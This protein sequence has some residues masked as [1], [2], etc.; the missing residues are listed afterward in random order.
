MTMVGSEELLMSGS[1]SNLLF[2]VFSEM[3]LVFVEVAAVGNLSSVV[4]CLLENQLENGS[5]E[6]RMR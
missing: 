4:L 1:S 3:L 2:A 6:L 5:M